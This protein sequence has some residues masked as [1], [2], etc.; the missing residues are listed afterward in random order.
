MQNKPEKFSGKKRISLMKLDNEILDYSELKRIDQLAEHYQDPLIADYIKSP[1]NHSPLQFNT[2][3]Q[4]IG[5]KP[6]RR[7]IH[8]I[9]AEWVC[10]LYVHRPLMSGLVTAVFIALL[11]GLATVT[12]LSKSDYYGVK[13]ISNADV[14]LKSSNA[15]HYNGDVISVKNTDTLSILYRFPQ[16]QRVYLFYREDDGVIESFTSPD[17]GYLWEATNAFV[18][19]PQQIVLEGEWKT[20]VVWVVV[21]DRPLKAKMVK[22][23]I[24]KQKQNRSVTS[25]T[26]LLQNK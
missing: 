23:L 25:F 17:T 9:F 3:W 24:D 22:S 6:R 19:A 16:N 8:E 2:V 21:S 11:W 18:A 14:S 12:P 13:G 26:F 5:D 4:R 7:Y 15:T 1:G 20:Q 10:S